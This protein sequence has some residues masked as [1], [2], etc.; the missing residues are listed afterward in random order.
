VREKSK[1]KRFDLGAAIKEAYEKF[2]SEG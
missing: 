2:R 1:P